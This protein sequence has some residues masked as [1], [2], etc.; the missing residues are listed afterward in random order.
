MQRRG[1][2]NDNNP[3]PGNTA[4]H[5]IRYTYPTARSLAPTTAFQGRSPWERQLPLPLSPG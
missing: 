3:Q 5:I 4:M 2:F 1:L